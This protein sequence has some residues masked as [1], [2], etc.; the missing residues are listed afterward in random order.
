L[1]YDY[2]VVAIGAQTATYNI[3]GVDEHTH[4]L[5]SVQQAQEIR[6]NILDSF[7]TAALPGQP[8]AEQR[9]LLH[10]VV[11]GGGPTGVEFSAELRDYVKGD[12]LKYY[13][14][15]LVEKCQ[16][17]LVDGLNKILNTYSEE[18]SRYTES[19]F[20]SEGINIVMNTFVTEID[21]NNMHLMDSKT[22]ERRQM[23]YGMC[24]WCAGISPRDLTKQ[25]I[26]DIPEQTNRM[27]L[28]TD[29]HFKVK[30]SSNIFA[31][32][33]CAT[34]QNVQFN[35][36]IEDLFSYQVGELTL[37][38][39]EKVLEEGMRK[40]PKF[41]HQLTV[42]KKDVQSRPES[43]NTFSSLQSLATKTS[44]K[45]T[46]LPPTAQVAAQ[47][48]KYLGKLLSNHQEEIMNNNLN[49][50]DPFKYNHLGS[51]AYVGDNRAVLEL[52]IIGSMMGWSTML[53]WR[54]TYAN[55]CVSSRMRVL[56]VL[57]WIKSYIFGRDTSR[58]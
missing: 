37:E 19:R 3:K 55:D 41:C 35:K 38:Q 22:K 50:V 13:P 4:Y 48:G 52:P 31:V 33:D 26:T 57:D 45:E 16:I 12:L 11:V 40:H 17:T 54:G 27:A 56:V 24:V 36:V 21:K 28:I 39:T 32:G 14:A 7:E 2:V 46:A 43:M 15:D 9:R 6:K 23:N 29:Q 1:D 10:F 34:I 44:A 47:E 42:M 30:N 25:L 51:F 5:K 53:L 58:I 20:K 49:D 8:D 18:I